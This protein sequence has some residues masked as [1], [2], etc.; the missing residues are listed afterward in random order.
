MFCF[1]FFLE[2]EDKGEYF[3][4]STEGGKQQNRSLQQYNLKRVTTVQDYKNYSTAADIWSLGVL[5]LHMVSYYPNEKW[6]RLPRTFAL[7][8]GERGM[9]F[10]WMVNDMMVPYIFSS[11]PLF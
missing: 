2:R 10:R 3:V 11:K 8:M 9:P 1:L 5:V 4:A 7:Q 6:H